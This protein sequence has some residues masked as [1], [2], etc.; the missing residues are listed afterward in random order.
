MENNRTDQ[1]AVGILIDLRRARNSARSKD[2]SINRYNKKF[3]NQL[4]DSFA[5][6]FLRID[7]QRDF[8][9]GNERSKMSSDFVPSANKFFML[10]RERW[11]IIRFPLVRRS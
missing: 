5:G 7:I 11:T 9:I 1:N 8:Y 2:A 4:G 6:N 3:V 10:R